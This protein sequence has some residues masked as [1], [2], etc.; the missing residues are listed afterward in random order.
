MAEGS[1]SIGSFELFEVCL[2]SF[3]RAAFRMAARSNVI[4][5]FAWR[6]II[7]WPAEL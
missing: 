1:A 2:P 4:P 3:G 6:P 7:E 5:A